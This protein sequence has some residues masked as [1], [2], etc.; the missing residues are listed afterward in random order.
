MN[1]LNLSLDKIKEMRSIAS[2]N[3]LAGEDW[4][5]WRFSGRFLIAPGKAGRITP[6]RLLGILWEEQAR[7]RACPKPSTP[8]AACPV[9]AL[10][11]RLPPRE[12]FDGYA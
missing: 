7:I 3:A 12:T 5:G 11:D 10:A 8:P 4:A 9:I 2:D 1:D 6:A